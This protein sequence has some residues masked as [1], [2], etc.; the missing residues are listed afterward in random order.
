M[1]KSAKTVLVVDDDPLVKQVIEALAAGQG[2]EPVSYQSPKEALGF[3]EKNFERIDLAIID[4]TMPD[5]NGLELVD[6]MR[7]ISRSSQIAILTGH[8]AIS[9]DEIKK[10]G[11]DR[12]VYKPVTKAEF[13]EAL[14]ETIRSCETSEE[15]G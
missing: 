12:I 6:R 1:T 3:F 2:C 13:I 10:H 9:E 11:V 14:N 7:E 8:A 15:T 4:L 5:M